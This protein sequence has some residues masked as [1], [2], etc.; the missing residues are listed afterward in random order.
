VAFPWPLTPPTAAHRAA[1]ADAQVGS[2]WL[3]DLPDR[4]PS[5]SLQ[6]TAAADLCIVGGG[7]TGLWAALQARAATPGRRVIVLEAE[8]VGFGG[9]GRNGGFVSSSL[10][11]GVAN[12]LRRFPDELATLERLGLENFDGLVADLETYTIDCDLEQPGEL[13]V[14][15]E[16]HEVLALG[17]DAARLQR[18]GQPV[19][20]LD[21]AAV[22]EL[23][24]SP[25]L[26]AGLLERQGRA[27]VHPGKLIEGLRRAALRAGVELYE[28]TPMR[29][30]RPHGA[31]VEIETPGG[32]VEAER[33]LLAVGAERLT[34]GLRRSIAPIY[35]YV[36]VSEPL[37]AQQRTALGWAGRQGVSDTANRFHYYRLTPDDRV[38]WGGYDAVY[39]ARGR[40]RP[41]Y[42][43]H[44][45]TFATL[46]QHF[47]TAFP[48]LEGLRFTHRWGGAIDACS[49]L[50]VFFGTTM[51]GRVAYAA[52]YTGLGVGASRWGAQVAVDLLDGRDTEATRLRFVRR[53]PLLIP[54]EPLRT[55]LIALTRNRL[56]AADRA[57]GRR[58][59]WLRTLDRLGVGFD[60]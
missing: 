11:H 9:S 46:S 41:E 59:R 19:E 27:L 55:P 18:L 45:P 42:D 37:D 38:L 23:V 30:M 52:G 43:D 20:L 60:T 15:L 56:A 7:F 6:G 13:R 22:Q 57:E 39:R 28:Q 16:D 25:L 54:P 33:V 31:G 36:L 2:F 12:G 58:G 4:V 17:D 24:E 32:V 14:A 40:V 34:A 50:S 49:R 5:P 35:D 8:R 48:Q 26:R 44:D 47:F 51:R 29:H 53:K 3:D 1:Y 10:T 21:R